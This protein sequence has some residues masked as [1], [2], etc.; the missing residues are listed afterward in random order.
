MSVNIENSDHRTKGFHGTSK[1]SADEIIRTG[2]VKSKPDSGA[3]LGE[4]VYFFENQLTN[5]KNW[6]LRRSPVGT[7][8]A[9]IESDVRYGRLLNLADR[10][11]LDELG[12]FR[13][14]LERKAMKAISFAT[15]VDVAA[16]ALN[17]DVV[18]ANRIVGDPGVKGPGFSADIEMILAVRNLSN[19]LSKDLVWS[20]LVE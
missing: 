16:A 17:V 6:A 3:Y 4:G 15:A 10:Q 19:I 13:K 8:V 20:G 18:K 12:W 9:V 5:A 1:I 7:Q 2:Y 14:G 11:H